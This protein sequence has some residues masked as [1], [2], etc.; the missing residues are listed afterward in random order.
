MYISFCNPLFCDWPLADRPDCHGSNRRDWEPSS[1]LSHSFGWEPGVRWTLGLRLIIYYSFLS[2]SVWPRLIQSWTGICLLI[3]RTTPRVV[4]YPVLGLSPQHC[5]LSR[6]QDVFVVILILSWLDM[7]DISVL[8][9]LSF[10]IFLNLSPYKN[11]FNLA[12]IL[13][14]S[15]LYIYMFQYVCYIQENVLRGQ[16]LWQYAKFQLHLFPLLILILFF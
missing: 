13:S 2:L 8:Q 6:I 14:S 12:S 1:V 3:H 10:S 16:S 7:H 5:S 4:S 11:I 15:H 9:M